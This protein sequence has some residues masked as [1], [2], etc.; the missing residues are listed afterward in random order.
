MSVDQ[1]QFEGTRSGGS[2]SRSLLADARLADQAAW[3]RLVR[4]YAPLVATWCRRRGIAEQDIGDLLQEVFAAVAAHLGRFRSERPTDTFRGWLSTITRN[5]VHDHFRRRAVEPLAA[6]GSEAAR[7]LQ[8][9]FD[10]H[11]PV[12]AADTENSD[13]ID[14]AVW[15]TLLQKALVS[16]RNEFHERTWQAFWQVAIE[17]RAAADVAADLNMKPGTVRVAKSRVL[18]RLRRELGDAAE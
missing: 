11:Q 17:G 2:T 18:L 15:D 9:V 8:Q 16:I 6:G 14:E 5:K 3:E 12:E 4:L 1:S 7:Q 10:Q 13:E